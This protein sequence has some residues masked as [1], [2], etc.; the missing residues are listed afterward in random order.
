MQVAKHLGHLEKQEAL[1]TL[2]THLLELI[3]HYYYKKV[4]T[5][6]YELF[7]MAFLVLDLIEVVV[8]YLVVMKQ[9]K[10]NMILHDVQYY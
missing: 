1:A 5:S 7:H 10:I 3:L 8:I 9:Y 4:H 2:N 6:P